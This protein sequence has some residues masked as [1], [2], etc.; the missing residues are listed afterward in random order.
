MADYTTP[1]KIDEFPA[2]TS[3]SAN[4]RMLILQANTTSGNTEIKLAN[5]SAFFANV[6]SV[7]VTNFVIG[8][9]STPSNSTMNVS[10]G[11]LWFDSNYL[12]FAVANNSIKRV[13][14]SSF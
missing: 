14:L 13:A 5:V 11:T 12:Y 10:Q 3:V 6:T 9:I 7:K 1:V 4:S 2:A 8:N